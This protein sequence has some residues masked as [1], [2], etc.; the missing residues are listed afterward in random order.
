MEDE[1]S[2]L[3]NGERLEDSLCLV[4]FRKVSFEGGGSLVSPTGFEPVT[5]GSGGGDEWF[6]EKA[7]KWLVFQY[8][9]HYLGY[10]QARAGV[11]GRM[12]K[13]AEIPQFR[14]RR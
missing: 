8:S 11:R 2:A 4:V 13:I 3:E 12:R 5:F 9:T 10:L 14:E 1:D 7:E 6:A